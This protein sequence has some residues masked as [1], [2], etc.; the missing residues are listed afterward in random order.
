[1]GCGG[2]KA[3]FVMRAGEGGM[4]FGVKGG[5]KA[6]ETGALHFSDHR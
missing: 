2:S 5:S 4:L 1:M 3:V 6:T